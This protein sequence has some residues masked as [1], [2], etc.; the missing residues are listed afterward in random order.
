MT[1]I[2]VITETDV[3]ARLDAL[4]WSRFHWL[5][6]AALG[7]TWILDGLEVTVVGA[8]SGVL[9]D[10]RTLRL[11][12]E[13]IGLAGSAYVAG[14]VVGALVFCRLTDTLGRKLL[15]PLTL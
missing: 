8:L 5:V 7:I 2:P 15:F 10:S 9:G 4:P 13:E 12:P 1:D 11:S 3:P 6:V 14:A